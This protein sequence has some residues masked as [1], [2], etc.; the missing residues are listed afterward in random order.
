LKRRWN[1]PTK[2]NFAG[3]KQTVEVLKVRIADL[4]PISNK[5]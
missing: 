3:G 4:T 5:S 2:T 1:K